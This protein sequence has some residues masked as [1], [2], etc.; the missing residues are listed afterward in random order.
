MATRERTTYVNK[1]GAFC[2][3]EGCAGCLDDRMA[4]NEAQLAY[5]LEQAGLAG[6][7]VEAVDRM[8]AA[9][10]PFAM[11]EAVRRLEDSQGYR[12]WRNGRRWSGDVDR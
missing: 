11:P 10:P 4:L 8:L 3:D 2:G 12:D 7:A 5:V 9:G 6:R 1:N